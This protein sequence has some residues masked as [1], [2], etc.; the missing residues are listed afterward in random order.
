VPEATALDEPDLL[1]REIKATAIK[2]ESIGQA[3][4]LLPAWY[5]IP[6]G[7]E[8]GDPKLN[9]RRGIDLD[10][11]ETNVKKFLDAVVAKDPRYTWKLEE[12]VIHVWPV[13][14][15]DTLVATLLDTKISH[16]AF[17]GGGIR[18]NIFYDIM[19]LP[20]LRSKLVIAGV[21]PLMFLNFGNI[22]KL[23]KGIFFS[24]TNLTL[25][26]LLDRIVLKTEIKR[27]LI[28]R[29]GENSEFIFLG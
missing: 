12:G 15:R 17:T 25:R 1:T 13:T 24:E 14:G 5:R 6:V 8:L 18:N 16:F 23:E 2:G 9:P 3:L 26:E 7:I 11:P 10:L 28:T 4:G 27:W 19:N 22:Q 29:W 21:D 20:E